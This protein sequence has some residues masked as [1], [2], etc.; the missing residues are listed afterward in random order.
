MFGGQGGGDGVELGVGDE[1]TFGEGFEFLSQISASQS[2]FTCGTSGK[3]SGRLNVTYIFY[4][5]QRLV[6]GGSSRAFWIHDDVVVDVSSV[7]C[8]GVDEGRLNHEGCGTDG[9]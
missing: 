7:F 5:A 2:T 3:E 1:A 9:G 6:V 4:D 8:S